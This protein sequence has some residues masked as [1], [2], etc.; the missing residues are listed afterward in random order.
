[1]AFQ[2]SFNLLKLSLS[3]LTDCIFTGDSA[4]TITEKKISKIGS[5]DLDVPECYF[6]TLFIYYSVGVIKQCVLFPLIFI[7]LF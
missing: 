7:S 6:N 3:L 2:E 1:M 4:L 5:R